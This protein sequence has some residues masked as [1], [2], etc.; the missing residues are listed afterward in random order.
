MTLRRLKRHSRGLGRGWESNPHEDATFIKKDN[1]IIM[2]T[3]KPDLHNPDEV[4]K[5]IKDYFAECGRTGAFPGNCGLYAALGLTRTE[6]YR[7][8]NG[9]S[10]SR[11]SPEAVELIERACLTL[12]GMREAAFMADGAFFPFDS[13]LLKARIVISDFGGRQPRKHKGYVRKA[14]AEKAEEQKP[15]R[16]RGRKKKTKSGESAI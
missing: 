14:D 15:V 12:G 5:A 6:A 3:N 9:R 11:A 1:K 7:I 2:K 4:N 13:K 8:R 16:K 10:K